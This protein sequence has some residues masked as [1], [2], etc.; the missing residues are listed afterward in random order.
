MLC[1]WF[2]S[3]FPWRWLTFFKMVVDKFQ[4]YDVNNRLLYFFFNAHRHTQ[5]NPSGI[6]CP[7]HHHH[8]VFLIPFVFPLTLAYIFQNRGWRNPTIWC[9]QFSLLFLFWCSPTHSIKSFRESRVLVII[10]VL[11]FWFHACLPWLWLTLFYFSKLWLTKSTYMM[12]TTF[13]FYDLFMLT[14][15]LNYNF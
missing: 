13:F 6:P 14:D 4:R 10:I 9:W 7:G 8:V 12:L 2:H 1:F 5:L 11:L 3:C 15:T